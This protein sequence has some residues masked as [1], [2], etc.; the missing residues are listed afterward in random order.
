MYGISEVKPIEKY[1]MLFTFTDGKRVLFD[2]S[3]YEREFWF[4]RVA[5]RFLDYEFDISGIW[6]G[7]DGISPIEIYKYGIEL[8][9]IEAVA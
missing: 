6:W 1:A 3:K 7:E 4:E 5:G 9:K 8:S 2:F